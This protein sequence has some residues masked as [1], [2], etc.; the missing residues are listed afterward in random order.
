MTRTLLI[1]SVAAALGLAGAATAA[2]FTEVDADANGLVS[3]QEV[4]AI[5]PD[6][7]ED[8][9]SSYDGD[10]DGSLNED[11]FATWDAAANAEPAN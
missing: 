1:T 9:F 7:T 3:L 4:Q 8:E 10:A 5:A 11:E 6:V 2:D